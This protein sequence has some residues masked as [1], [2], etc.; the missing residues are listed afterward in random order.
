MGVM[1]CQL[2]AIEKQVA[3]VPEIKQF[4]ETQ[5]LLMDQREDHSKLHSK[6]YSKINS[7]E[8]RILEAER[9]NRETRDKLRGA[10]D[11]NRELKDEPTNWRN[12][13]YNASKEIDRLT[14]A[15]YILSKKLEKAKIEKE[16]VEA[17]QMQRE[18]MK[19][20][21]TTPS[22]KHHNKLSPGRTNQPP[23]TSDA[24]AARKPST[25]LST[26]SC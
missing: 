19:E 1:K 6:L 17:D 26:H 8:S 2:D 7:L 18:D 23:M 9:I 20:R 10:I 12:K 5:K 24:A 13:A 16:K 3:L 22:K 11:R 4:M 21:A 14:E 15:T 25:E